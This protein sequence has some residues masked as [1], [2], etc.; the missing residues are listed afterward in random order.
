MAGGYKVPE[1]SVDAV[2]LSN[3]CIANAHGS[4]AS[5]YNPA[6]MSFEQSKRG[7]LELDLTYVGL[8][9]VDYKG[10]TYVPQPVN[11]KVP[12]DVSSESEDFVIP[13]LHYVSPAFGNTRIGLSVVTPS[14]LSKKWNDAPAS[15]YSK[16]FSLTT[17]EINPNLSYK[18]NNYLSVGGGLEHCIQMVW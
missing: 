1:S 4:D 18:I 8:S 14:G 10:T 16:E 5:Y 17:V 12:T 13:S 7:S 11:A 6:N 3:A 2:A 15:L 9:S